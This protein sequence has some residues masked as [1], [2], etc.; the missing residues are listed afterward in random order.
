M[1]IFFVYFQTDNA[2]AP[3]RIGIS[4]GELRNFPDPADEIFICFLYPAAVFFKVPQGDLSSFS[5]SYNVMD[6]QGSCPKAVFLFSA[7]KKG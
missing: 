6:T 4:Q 1:E 5:E 3:I 7:V 2:R